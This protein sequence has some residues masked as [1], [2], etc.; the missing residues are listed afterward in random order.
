MSPIQPYLETLG[1]VILA[2]CGAV[3]GRVT[4]RWQWPRWGIAYAM[5][6]SLIGAIALV[7]CIPHLEYIVPFKWIMADRTEFA[8]FG[9][10]TTS[11]LTIPMYRLPRIR[12]RVLVGIFAWLI[13]AIYSL[14]PFLLPGLNYAYLRDLKTTVDISGVCLQS[15]D[16]NCGP[17]AAV[18][19]LRQLG[20]QAEEGELA[21]LAHTTRFAGTPVD[22]LS[23][24]I[25]RRYSA[26]GVHCTVRSFESISDLRQFPVI[27]VV[28]YGFLVDHYV[29]VLSV[30]DRVVELGD[31]LKGKV[32]LSHQLFLDK[33]R[34]SG[35]VVERTQPDR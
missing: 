6:L 27:A 23:S 10:L 16:Y 29:V 15:N 1:V 31:P 19:A 14:L 13:V 22:S 7:R 24:A 9:F 28:K 33:W 4:S 32:M 26:D 20:I 12:Q 21:I 18:T 8:I 34:K 2:V 3:F 17:A 11:A 30:T 5:P 25:T 35:I